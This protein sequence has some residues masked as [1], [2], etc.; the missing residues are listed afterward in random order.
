[1]CLAAAAGLFRSNCFGN[2]KTIGRTWSGKQHDGQ[3]HQPAPI[4]HP[5]TDL[6]HLEGWDF[7]K[8]E[9]RLEAQLSRLA[10]REG[11]SIWQDAR[12]HEATKWTPSDYLIV[13][14]IP[15]QL[16]RSFILILNWWC[17]IH[18]DDPHDH[19]AFIIWHFAHCCYW[20]AHNRLCICY[21]IRVHRHEQRLAWCYGC[22][23]WACQIYAAN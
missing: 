14:A 22:A 21:V 4:S 11:L 10:E 5:H 2:R 12:D 1:M 13:H 18:V 17:S 16:M 9:A 7:I 23:F 8:S 3:H 20:F 6:H 15:S 19:V